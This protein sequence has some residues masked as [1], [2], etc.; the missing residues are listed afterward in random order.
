MGR[1]REGGC[2]DMHSVP[3]T[4]SE[5]IGPASADFVADQYNTLA[6]YRYNTILPVIGL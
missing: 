2:G 3:C 5:L 6:S 1:E 4:A